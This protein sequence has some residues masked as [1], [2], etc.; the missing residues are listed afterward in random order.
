MR[1]MKGNNQAWPWII[2]TLLAQTG[3]GAYPVLARY[4]QTVTSLPSMS[5]IAFGSLVALLVVGAFLFPRVD[6]HSFRSKRLLFFAMIVVGRGISN[7]LAARFTLAIYVQ[8]ITLSTPFLVALLST[9]VLHERLP[10]YTGRAISIS[11]FG[12]LLIIGGGLLAVGSLPEANR[13]DWLGI[14]LAFASSLLLAIYMISVRSSARYNIKGE[15]LLLVQ[16]FALAVTG[17]FL[18][19]VLGEDW[20][21]WQ[22]MQT[23]D[24]LIFAILSLGILA[25]ANIAQI[26]SIR[27]LGAAMVSSTMAWRLVSTLF[28]AALLLGERLSSP[29]Q[30]LGVGLV[31]ATITWYLWYQQKP[32]RLRG[33]GG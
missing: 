19:L 7:F 22:T 16:L 18:S 21:K 26:G 10:R 17:G 28:L 20:S 32:A 31:L 3:W 25:G 14:L 27:Q 5:I 30:L 33:R 9:A 15:T 4:L 23:V 8:L 1:G 2:A 11:L 6:W 24:W 13:T 29:L 12:A